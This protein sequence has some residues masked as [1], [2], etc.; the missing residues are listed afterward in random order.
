MWEVV[1]TN[2][3]FE[4][5][6][7]LQGTGRREWILFV[8]WVGGTTMIM[9]LFLTCFVLSGLTILIFG[10]PIISLLSIKMTGPLISPTHWF[11]LAESWSNQTAQISNSWTSI[12]EW[13]G[14]LQISISPS[15]WTSLKFFSYINSWSFSQDSLRQFKIHSIRTNLL[16]PRWIKSN[17][18]GY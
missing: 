7:S 3:W 17:V 13:P 2:F 5:V 11:F 4:W 14:L 6:K 1:A 9:L 18:G 15:F 16:S 10:L 8:R 12:Q